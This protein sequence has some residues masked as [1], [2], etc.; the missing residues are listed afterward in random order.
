MQLDAAVR[1]SRITSEKD[2]VPGT[3]DEVG[4]LIKRDVCLSAGAVM[5]S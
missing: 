3:D 1:G 4:C 2:Q 5:C